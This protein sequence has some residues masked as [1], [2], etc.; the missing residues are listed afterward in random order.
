[1]HPMAVELAARKMAGAGDLRKAL[2][3]C[4]QAIEMVEKELV[5][6]VS[7]EQPNGLTRVFLETEIESLDQVPQVLAKH[8][9][10]ATSAIM[11]SPVVHRIRNLQMQ[12]KLLLSTI[13]LM[14][15]LNTA[16][17]TTGNVCFI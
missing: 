3:V 10:A 2:D 8:V 16:D 7:S 4:R 11:G 1:M 6:K 9:L 13:A 14:A 15:H 17:L 5:A 12:S